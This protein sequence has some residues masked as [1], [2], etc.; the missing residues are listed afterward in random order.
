MEG[1]VFAHRTD[2]E[3]Q[4]RIRKGDAMLQSY[5]V[6]PIARAKV[7]SRSITCGTATIT[8]VPGENERKGWGRQASLNKTTVESRKE[9]GRTTSTT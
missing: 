3:K 5:C 7:G 4:R 6:T 2:D 9:E 8:D 1:K